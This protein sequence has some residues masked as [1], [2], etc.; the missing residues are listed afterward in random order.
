MA[1]I[2]PLIL[3]FSAL[4]AIVYSLK[5]LTQAEQ[6]FYQSNF[7]TFIVRHIKQ[8]RSPQEQEKRF[9]IWRQNFDFIAKH[10]EKANAGKKSY[11]L[12]MNEYGD[13]VTIMLEMKTPYRNMINE[14]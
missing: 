12:K 8:Y 10:N 5:N 7:E 1:R 9:K 4:I 14:N 13:L 2:I 11:W 6:K 3:L